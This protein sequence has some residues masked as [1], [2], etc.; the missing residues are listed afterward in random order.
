VSDGSESPRTQS[1]A[2]G[3]SLKAT[4]G[5]GRAASDGGGRAAGAGRV[6]ARGSENAS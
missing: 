5:S 6:S 4:V 1:R 3:W 2:G